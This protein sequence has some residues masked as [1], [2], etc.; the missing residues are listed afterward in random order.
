[1][2]RQLSCSGDTLESSGDCGQDAHDVFVLSIGVGGFDEGAS[3]EDLGFVSS[4]L[5]EVQ[6]A[7]GQLGA[8]LE[9]AL[10]PDEGEIEAL[11]RR[12]LVD[13]RAP[14][15]VIVVHLIGHGRADRS[16][17]LGFVARDDR[18]VD[19]DRWIEKAQQEVER[20]GGRRRV[21]FLVDTCSAGVA[22]GRQQ[23]SELDGERGVWLLG[24][25]VSGSPTQ[26]GRFSGWV[27]TALHRLRY[28]DFSLTA[29]T[30]SFALFVQSLV[31]VVRADTSGQRLSLGFSA[32]QGDGDWPF[33][34][35][36]QRA[37]LTPEQIQS[38][39]RSLGYVPGE[40]DLRRD[41]GSRIAAGE[42]IGDALYF[43]DRASGRGLVPVAAGVG[44]F[45]GRA[46][47]LKQYIAWQSGGSPLLTVTGA[48]GAG[49][50]GLLGVIVCAAHS[51][52]RGRVHELW[53]SAGQPL[54]EIPDVVALHARQRSAQQVIDTIVG[55]A[56]LQ[57]PREEEELLPDGPEAVHESETAADST[58]WT[59]ALL[60]R[61]LEQEDKSRLIVLD[62]VDE[63]TDP[64]SVLQVVA[65]LVAPKEQ[66]G[67]FAKPP[68]R[69][70]LGGRHEVIAALS[71]DDRMPEIEVDRIDLDTADPLTV[72][73]DVRRYVEQLLRTREPYT[74]GT[75]AAFVGL[76]AKK[77]AQGI[78]QGLR[79]DS[80]WGPFL[81]AGLYV[82][83]LLTLRYPPQDKSGAEAHA[84][85]ASANLPDLLEAV[86]TA[87]GEEYPSLRAVLAILARSRGDGMPRTALRRCLRALDADGLDDEQFVGTL[88]DASPFLRTGIDPV[89]KEALYRI[90]QQGLAD[91]LHDHPVG[92]EPWEAA[93]HVELERKLLS[94]LVD[95]FV[96]D[97][98]ERSDRW[99]SAESPAEPYV[100]RHALGHVTAAG[101]AEYAEALLADPY[102]LVRF[103]PR[104]DHR[105]LDLAH[106]EQ[107]AT[108]I[109]LLNASWSTHAV[110]T[111]GTDRALVF[112]FDADRLGLPGHRKEF[113]RIAKELAYQSE[114]SAAS[115][116]WSEGGPAESNARIVESG[117]S[118]V[119]SMAFSPN[120]DLLATTGY[121]GARILETETWRPVSPIIGRALGGSITGVA[122]SS[123]GRLLALG[124]SSWQRNVQLWDVNDR[125]PLGKPWRH[126]TGEVAALAF[127]P[128]DRWLALA[129]SD[130]EAS[131][132]DIA[133]DPPVVVARLEGSEAAGKVE[134]S[135]DGRFLALCGDRGLTL[136]RTDDW[137]SKAQLSHEETLGIAFSARG[138]FL[139]A[140]H[141]KK[142]TIWSGETFSTATSVRLEER[143][144]PRSVACHPNGSLLAV[145]GWEGLQLIDIPSRCVA[146]RLVT[147]GHVEPLAFHPS[148]KML[149][150]SA[151]GSGGSLHLWTTFTQET[152]LPQLPE[153][154][155]TAV[156]AS[157]DGRLV[158]AHDL[159]KKCLILRDP[160]T[161]REL[162][163]IPLRL[164][165]SLVSVHFSPDSRIL[166][167]LGLD[168][169]IHVFR[170]ELPI[171]PGGRIIRSGT[172]ALFPRFK[173]EFSPDSRLMA[174]VVH[175]D[176]AESYVIKVW[177]SRNL[178]LTARIA[179]PRRPSAF[180]FAGPDKIYVG[181]YG[182]VAVYD[183]D[184]TKSEELPS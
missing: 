26:G 97:P 175:G 3:V 148:A 131:V 96:A 102:F 105:A 70:L 109:R 104:E 47:E 24:A 64:Q 136:W 169:L 63:S 78:V 167:T 178:R 123:D 20:D 146:D 160:S 121:V 19:V 85:R 80:P 149:L 35:T 6:D 168:D 155:S 69:I 176:H 99:E 115:F 87:R 62:A 119:L 158:A 54:P 57:R 12:W 134:F 13:E 79:P 170:T 137:K 82:H 127:S 139:A 94:E 86:L 25:S 91:Y 68:C 59:T 51:D 98:A 103:D 162:A 15:R 153:F 11:L 23:I 61:A 110:L 10:D 116:L 150:V 31:Q 60:R 157:P 27:A 74:T 126:R 41:L 66:D 21:V 38:Q 151:G 124:S 89:T 43:I 48:A 36:P 106:S 17:R 183:C 180:G 29:E 95:P 147:A 166:A 117:D 22:T 179:L 14:A 144:R 39:R 67:T 112:A 108:H 9:R 92:E 8:T 50:S 145:G 165:S 130:F 5:D 33:L 181:M 114:Q 182:S 75:S 4:R 42:E 16:G 73:E 132:W 53:A 171:D 49:K 58:P 174:L 88:R 34:P 113:S 90:F 56:R 177:E 133:G 83:Y 44:F 172:E 159:Q 40:E 72:E 164:R 154:Q 37:N 71:A 1:M 141:E 163:S 46:T 7:F 138:G 84:G 142:V 135:P 100:F 52:L 120:G 129:S 18:D 122:F 143:I 173:I 156:A 184:G 101:S 55:H 2:P 128:D 30:I 76:L 77:G 125:I 111:S 32:T 161:G 28:R 93:Q 45:S 118:S 107:A 140:L 65:E 152:D 81:L